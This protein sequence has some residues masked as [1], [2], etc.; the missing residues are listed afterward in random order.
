MRITVATSLLPVACAATILG[1]PAFARSDQDETGTRYDADNDM[2]RALGAHRRLG[3]Q[4][5]QKLT[6]EQAR[7]QPTPADAAKA[8]LEAQGKPLDPA[9]LVPSVTARDTTIPSVAGPL[10]VRIY[11]PHGAEPFPVIVYYHGGGWVL[12]DREVYDGG[13]RGLAKQA[14]AVVVSVDYRRAPEHHFPTARDDALAVYQWVARNV[15]SIHLE[16]TVHPAERLS[17][18]AVLVHQRIRLLVRH[19]P[20]DRLHDFAHQ[21]HRRSPSSVRFDWRYYP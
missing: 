16:R 13:A 6:V 2:Q 15:A 1:L 4:P 3:P 21:G 11:T 12:A 17:D 8:V 5:I 9:R 10:P 20:G 14:D 7:T 18:A 19:E